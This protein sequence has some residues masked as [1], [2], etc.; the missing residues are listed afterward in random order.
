[1]EKQNLTTFLEQHLNEN[2][3]HVVVRR[4]FYFDTA[5][6]EYPLR[7]LERFIQRDEKLKELISRLF[8]VELSNSDYSH[9]K[10]E[11][12]LT[13]DHVAN[14]NDIP[15]VENGVVVGYIEGYDPIP[16]PSLQRFLDSGE[17]NYV[18]HYDGACKQKL[19][20]GSVSDFNQLA[21][22]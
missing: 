18:P 7:P 11:F 2:P 13:K 3:A 5:L 17:L 4:D 20:F 6:M 19:N 15:V 10:T 14:R 16:G 8:D 1:M 12:L 9:E 22:K 21:L